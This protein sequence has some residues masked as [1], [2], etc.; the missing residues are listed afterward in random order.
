MIIG[1]GNAKHMLLSIDE[2]AKR[3]KDKK[4]FKNWDYMDFEEYL[5]DR[6]GVTSSYMDKGTPLYEFDSINERFIARQINRAPKDI[7]KTLKDY[8]G[9]RIDP[10]DSFWEV[11]DNA[12]KDWSPSNRK[13]LV[14][15][16]VMRVGYRNEKTLNYIWHTGGLFKPVK[17]IDTEENE[18]GEAEDDASS[19]SGEVENETTL[20]SAASSEAQ[21][22]SNESEMNV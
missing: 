13:V 16:L 14:Y 7:I 3:F 8:Y 15:T 18:A 6:L 4:G 22:T 17:R 20:E 21:Q 9:S 10:Q 11:L 12:D 19:T 2:I 1:R 5:E